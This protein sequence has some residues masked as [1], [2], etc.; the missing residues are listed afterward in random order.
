[1]KKFLTLVLVIVISVMFN[2]TAFASTFSNGWNGGEKLNFSPL[3]NQGVYNSSD[4]SKDLV[5][6]YGLKWY[7]DPTRSTLK[8]EV[9]LVQLR[10]IQASLKRR[11]YTPLSANGET[12]TNFKDKDSLSQNVQE[13]LK[14]LKSIGVLSGDSN[15]YM[16]LDYYITR[17]EASKVITFTNASVLGIAAKRNDVAFTDTVNHWGKPYI[18]YAYQI[19]VMDSITYTLFY[20]DSAISIEQVLDILDN[21]VGYYNITTQDVATAMNET[22]KVTYNLDSIRISPEYNSYNVKMY[23]QSQI[24]VNIYPAINNDL[25]FTS[26]DESICTVTSVNQ[27][28]DTATFKGIKVGTTYLKV[29]VKGEP[30]YFAIV[31]VYVTSNEVAATGITVNTNISLEVGDGYYLSTLVLPY[32]TTNKTVNYYS[33]NTN[34]ATVNSSGKVTGINSGAVVITAETSNGYKA[35]CIATVTNQYNYT[36]PA[37]GITVNNNISVEAGYAYYLT[38]TVSPYNATDKT[39]LYYINDSTIASVGI[40]GRVT[41]IRAGVTLITVQTNNGYKA[42]SVVTVTDKAVPATGITVNGNINLEVGNERYL[43]TSVL[44]YNATNKAVI[45]Y[46]SN[47]NIATVNSDGKVTAVRAGTTY[48]TAQ[49]HNGY[50]AQCIVTVTDGNVPTTGITVSTN[51]NLE[52]GN[53]SYLTTSVFPYNATNKAVIYYSS[54][55]NIATVNSDGRVTAVHEGTAYV[56]AQTYN[57]YSAQSTVRVTNGII[58][59]TG[60]TL[61]KNITLEVA[62]RAYLT[63][64]VWPYNTTDKT[65]RYYSSDTNIVSVNSD[66]RVTGVNKGTAVVTAQTSNGYAAYCTVTVNNSQ[67]SNNNP[68]DNGRNFMYVDGYGES[69]YYNAF[70]NESMTFI[71]DTNL[72]ITSVTLSNTNCYISQSV[73]SH[74]NGWKFTVKSLTLSQNGESLLT[75]NLSNGQQLT[76]RICIYP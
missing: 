44:P 8:G 34:I 3:V 29:N 47:S 63:A 23:E 17:A 40:D 36:I 57:G 39:V 33:S 22:F 41:G 49:A 15:N 12:L 24:K 19:G 4:W 43:T 10:T 6:K 52:V 46:S 18:S 11:G 26:Y 48:I 55:S 59:A 7:E 32:N 30:N 69:S 64:S 60:I 62:D 76:V 51:V 75:V 21:E 56:T 42:Y 25:E 1:M 20:P 50:T 73:S 28:L 14:I 67:V 13:E 74:A 27:Y 65:I 5:N 35:Y 45:Y 9:M 16:N 31:P 72:S 58:A 71:V 70:N 68:T 61:T 38:A 54:N 2:A 37:T 53:A 66:G